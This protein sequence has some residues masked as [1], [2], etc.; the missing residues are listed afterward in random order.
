MN[1]TL[2]QAFFGRG[3]RGYGVLGISPGI[4]GLVSRIEAICAS[5]G[6][7]GRDYGGEPFLMSVPDD[8]RVIMLCGRR[9]TPDSMERATLFFHVLVAEKDVL[10]AAKADAFSLFAQGAFTDKM[11]VG[12]VAALSL[13]ASGA[14]SGSGGHPQ[15]NKD[16]LDVTLPCMFRSR[17]AATELVRA[18][19]G[20]RANELTWTTF[21]FQSLHGFD[22][23]VLPP[24]VQG[25]RTLNEYDASTHLVSRASVVDA[26]QPEEPLYPDRKQEMSPPY[27]STSKAPLSEKSN[28]MIKFSIVANFV[29]VALCA[30][31]LVSRKSMSTSPANA[32]DQIVITN[33]VERIVEKP[34][35]TPLPDEQKATIEKVAIERYRSELIKAFPRKDFIGDF[36]DEIKKCNLFRFAYGDKYEGP[37]VPEED[38]KKYRNENTFLNKLKS[39]VNVLN[40]NLLKGK[41]P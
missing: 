12:N 32:T 37:S 23:Q 13:E 27:S 31:L 6:T 4:T 18:A 16:K 28:V 19:I 14:M 22:V 10:V 24:R 9:G 7:P 3:E 34:V 5:V 41:K 33:F 25:L 26:P 30:M 20:N 35:V 17:E 8:G 11:P 29:L 39:Y 36:D 2:D 38:K 15:D 1:I 21:A 40:T